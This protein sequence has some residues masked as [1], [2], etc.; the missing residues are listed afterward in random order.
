LQEVKSLRLG[1]SKTLEMLLGYH[2]ENENLRLA[3]GEIVGDN[4]SEKNKNSSLVS[5]SAN[6][7]S[8]SSSMNYEIN[9]DEKIDI[10]S[11]SIEDVDKLK[12]EDLNST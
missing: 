10:E 3:F 5:K 2:E 12:I 8:A 9:N 1:N 7:N 4:D 6:L 11:I